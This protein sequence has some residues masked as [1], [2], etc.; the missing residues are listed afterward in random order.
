MSEIITQLE[1]A[2][3]FQLWRLRALIDKLL[4]DPNRLMHVKRKLYLGKEITYFAPE[5]NRDITAIVINI[6]RTHVLVKNTCDGKQ[7]KLPL[8]VLNIDDLPTDVVNNNHQKVDRLSLKVGEKVGF[9]ARRK[10]SKLL[11]GVVTKLNPKTAGIKILTG[12][13]WR[14]SYGALFYVLE[15]E[16]EKYPKQNTLT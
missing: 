9:I 7:W 1:K 5:E 4:E 16:T 3:P 2:T 11:C 10:G 13:L 14:V 8:Y 15:A 12:E 6:L